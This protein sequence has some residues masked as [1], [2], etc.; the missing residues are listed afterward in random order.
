MAAYG[1]ESSRSDN[2]PQTAG[3]DPEATF[4]IESLSTA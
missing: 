4:D 1:S 2:A 3:V